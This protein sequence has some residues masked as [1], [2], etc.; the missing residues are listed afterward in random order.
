V[1]SLAVESA[2][3]VCQRLRERLALREGA[4]R[5]SDLLLGVD[6]LHFEKPEKKNARLLS[7][8]RLEPED[9]MVDRY[10]VLRSV[11]WNPLFIRQR[12]TNLVY[13]R[14]WY[15]GFDNLL[16]TVSEELTIH[17][18]TF[19]HDALCAFQH[20][21]TMIEPTTVSNAELTGNLPVST[22]GHESLVYRLVGIYLG[23]KL[24]GKYGLVW[25][26]CKGNPGKE[27]EYWEKK[28][29]LAR[30]AFLALRCR[31]DSDFVQYFVS[32]LCS[33]PQVLN[34]PAFVSLARALDQE[35][36]KIRTLTMLALS[37]Q[38]PYSTDKQKGENNGQ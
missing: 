17:S 7:S 18:N 33:V 24:K 2:L 36:D 1:I 8:T 9:R 6:V 20:E 13:D 21:G 27:K 30:E 16:S 35:T 5:T 37:A 28:E 14:S 38:S 25:E 26:E 29:K 32:T 23:R 15:A 12:L 22:P 11:L 31:I 3:D 34:E 19:R 10:T 4:T